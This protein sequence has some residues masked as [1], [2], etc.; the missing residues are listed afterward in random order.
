MLKLIVRII[1]LSFPVLLFS[2]K[3]DSIDLSNLKEPMYNPLVER[4][5]LDELMELR[6]QNQILRTE[7]TQQIVQEKLESSDR[8]VEYTTA[9]MN[10]I[11]FIMTTAAS[12]LV[13]V[14][15]RS[16]ND[17]KKSLKIDTARKLEILTVDYEVRLKQIETKM[18]ERSKVIIETQQNI[19]NTNSIHSL[20]MRAG[21]EKSEEDKISIYDEILTLNPRDLEALTYKADALLEVG[22]IRWALN[23]LNTA[24]EYDS[25]YSLGYWQRACAYAELGKPSDALKDLRKALEL[26]DTLQDELLN[27]KHFESLHD[28]KNFKTLLS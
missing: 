25:E 12:L 9:T 10:N 23:L 24:I 1:I 13:L 27:E 18:K 11:F 16:L 17:I 2:Q 5:I 15:W 3:K 6:K 22:E 20:W 7:I 14:G 8:A 28:N 21:L 19:T 26:S 4:Y